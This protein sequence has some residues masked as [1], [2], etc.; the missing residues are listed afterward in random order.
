MHLSIAIL[1]FKSDF[2]CNLSIPENFF[3]VFFKISVLLIII[4]FLR[5]GPVTT[6]TICKPKTISL[7]HFFPQ[8]VQPNYVAAYC[9]YALGYPFKWQIDNVVLNDRNKPLYFM[10]RL[11]Y[12]SEPLLV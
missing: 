11:Y 9:S 1:I 10:L 4:F 12:L 6:A 2:I 5:F 7:I 8:L 3:T